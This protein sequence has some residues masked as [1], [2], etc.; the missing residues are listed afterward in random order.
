MGI[1]DKLRGKRKSEKERFN[2]ADFLNGIELAKLTELADEPASNVSDI[3]K[4]KEVSEALR[5][6]LKKAE[7][8]GGDPFY[9]YRKKKILPEKFEYGMNCFLDRI[10]EISGEEVAQ[11]TYEEL[12]KGQRVIPVH[13]L[14]ELHKIR[15]ELKKE[16]E[17]PGMVIIL[18]PSEGTDLPGIPVLCGSGSLGTVLNAQN[19]A[20][21]R[22]I[23]DAISRK[24]FVSLSMMIEAIEEEKGA[25]FK[26]VKLEKFEKCCEE[27]VG[28]VVLYYKS[29]N[30]KYF[31][32]LDLRESRSGY[33][34][35]KGGRCVKLSELSIDGSPDIIV[36]MRR[37][38]NEKYFREEKELTKEEAK[39]INIVYEYF[40]GKPVNREGKN[41]LGI[42]EN[43]YLRI[44]E[45]GKE[46]RIIGADVNVKANNDVTALMVASQ[47]GN[48]EVVKA[49]LAGGADVNAKEDNEGGTALM[50]ASAKGHGKIV[51]TLL[52]NGADVNAKD[53]NGRT[54]LM[55]ASQNG[56]GE[57]VKVMLAR[58][59]DVNAKANNGGTALMW[60]SWNGRGN[61][62]M[63]LLAGG[64]D[65]NAKDNI[66]T[67]ALVGASREGH[68]KVVKILKKS[69][70]TLAVEPLIQAL[71][72][73]NEHVSGNAM[74]ILIMIGEPAVEP[75]IQVLKGENED[76]QGGA[77]YVLGEIGEPAVKPLIQALEDENED[78][79]INAMIALK[80]IGEPAVEPLIKALKDENSFVRMLSARALGEIGDERV[81]EPLSQALADE[82]ETV[83]K[84]AKEALEKIKAEKS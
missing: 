65:V 54:A 68:S 51:K 11:K 72:D 40:N 36:M 47:F 5:R 48:G 75:L 83:R 6:T 1:F 49:L 44:F 27:L 31:D 30:N 23:Q 71:E 70:A 14:R 52:D 35:S 19:R 25:V 29:K 4:Q 63:A 53:N 84:V 64:A 77:M 12:K 73:E 8:Y 24:F 66:G 3:S 34:Y 67:T 58:G 76:V 33:V 59:V 50:L 2:P 13:H 39:T 81:V 7:K 46:I 38:E 57:I 21:E 60:A 61:I 74:N 43:D 78:V 18:D 15:E 17:G 79:Q 20:V 80:R 41:F 45:N 69:G 32:F 37:S 10:F 82:V 22:I 26:R 62:V 28:K 55:K 42:L 9:E 56:Q 16:G